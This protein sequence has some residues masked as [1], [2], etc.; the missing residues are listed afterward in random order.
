MAL[1]WSSEQSFVKPWF[2]YLHIYSF[3]C[4]YKLKFDLFWMHCTWWRELHQNIPGACVYEPLLSRNTNAASV[5]ISWIGAKWRHCLVQLSALKRLSYDQ[6]RHNT[7]TEHTKKGL[8]RRFV[9]KQN[10]RELDVHKINSINPY[11]EKKLTST[12]YKKS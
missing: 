9:W 10:K 4:L 5:W 3:W 1:P 8:E 12:L 11:A 2:L 7:R 6:A